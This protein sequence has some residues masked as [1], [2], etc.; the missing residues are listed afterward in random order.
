MYVHSWSIYVE[1]FVQLNYLLLDDDNISLPSAVLVNEG[2][3]DLAIDSP[4]GYVNWYT[5]MCIYV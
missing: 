2:I 3:T 1:L 5:I 4:S